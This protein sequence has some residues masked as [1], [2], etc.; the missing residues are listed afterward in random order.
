[1]IAAAR[2][3]LLAHAARIQRVAWRESFLREVRE[4]ARTLALA[5][6]WLDEA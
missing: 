2:D 6:A 4:N 1:V 3:A 5:R